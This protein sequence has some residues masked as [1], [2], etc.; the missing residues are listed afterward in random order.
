MAKKSPSQTHC[1][2]TVNQPP[3][4]L[5]VDDAKAIVRSLGFTL[6]QWQKN[7]I[8]VGD[9]VAARKRLEEAS[10]V[11][12]RLS[13]GIP[14]PFASWDDEIN[15]LTSTLQHRKESTK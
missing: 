4:S 7:L 14:A 11:L 8:T 15:Q 2:P 3:H 13:R 5:R 1:I 12:D 6:K 10:V 9:I